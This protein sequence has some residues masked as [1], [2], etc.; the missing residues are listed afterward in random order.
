MN[1]LLELEAFIGSV[2]VKCPELKDN[3]LLKI[4]TAFCV[5][6]VLGKAANCHV[7]GEWFGK[8]GKLG[9]IS[10]FRTT[11]PITLHLVVYPYTNETKKTA[12][13]SNKNLCRSLKP[14][15]SS[16]HSRQEIEVT[17]ILFLPSLRVKHFR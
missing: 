7:G 16:R 12:K 13:T 6:L 3:F 9:A 8:V 15:Q 1:K 17:F 11:L 10:T 5:S 14:C 2:R 4:L